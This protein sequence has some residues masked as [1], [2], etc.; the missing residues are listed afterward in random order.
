MVGIGNDLHRLEAGR[1]LVLG[2]IEIESE[3]GCVAHSDG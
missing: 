2:G 3:L 1:R